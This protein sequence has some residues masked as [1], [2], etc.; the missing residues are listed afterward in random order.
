MAG[1][2]FT[3][4]KG[5]LQDL[6]MKPPHGVAV[7]VAR[8]GNL[9]ALFVGA[10]CLGVWLV[11]TLGATAAGLWFA[12]LMALTGWVSPVRR[13]IQ[14]TAWCQVTRSRLYS[15]MIESRIHSRTG[16]LPI[17][18]RVKPTKVGERASIWCVAGV[19]L[20][21]FESRTRTIGA[22]CYARDARVSAHKRWSHLITVEVIRRDTLGAL[23]KIRPS[24]LD[25][26]GFGK[27]KVPAP[28]KPLQ[29]ISAPDW[30]IKP[31][32]PSGLIDPDE[33][34]SDGAV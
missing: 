33:P 13:L 19:S 10:V 23:E 28:R 15:V 9:V 16:R 31:G 4:K 17:V 29:P 20:E 14:R 24:L 30:A 27:A 5:S 26:F 22:A 6:L 11:L 8:W 2:N 7:K 1:S 12:S 34:A 25:R 3:G 18:L 21:D 32:S